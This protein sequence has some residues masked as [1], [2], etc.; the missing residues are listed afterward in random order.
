MNPPIKTFKKG[1]CQLAIWQGDF[2]G[3]VTYSY[4]IKK[5]VYDEKTKVWSES[6]FF[7]LTDLQD[8][9]FLINTVMSAY[10]TKMSQPKKAVSQNPVTVQQANNVIN[11]NDEDIPF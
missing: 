4:S 2:Q 3:K 9:Y 10:I 11:G 7:S 5:T 6:I 8:T 1:K